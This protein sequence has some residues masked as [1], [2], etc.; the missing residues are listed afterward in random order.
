MM[1]FQV[2]RIERNNHVLWC[3]SVV[4]IMTRKKPKTVQYRTVHMLK[5][6]WSQ[7]K[8][9]KQFIKYQELL[10][11]AFF[12]KRVLR[13]LS[14]FFFTFYV[15]LASLSYY[16][17]M[18]QQGHKLCSRL[19]TLHDKYLQHYGLFENN[20]MSG[21]QLPLGSPLLNIKLIEKEGWFWNVE[22]YIDKLKELGTQITA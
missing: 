1:G 11:T 5:N 15:C 22:H 7:V 4:C 10:I 2:Y 17:S 3:A 9:F 14:V 12:S 6:K 16:Y 19:I 20:T 21:R 18:L 8:Q 13:L